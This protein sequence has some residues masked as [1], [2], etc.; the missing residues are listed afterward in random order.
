VPVT[1]ETK[2]PPIYDAVVISDYNKG[3]ITYELVEEI[4]QTFRGPVFI[5]TK[6]TELARFEG[7]FVKINSLENSL[8]KTLPSNLIVTLGKYGTRYN[9]NIY[10]AA[11]VEVADVC[12]AGDTFLAALVYQYLNTGSLDRAIEYANW[13]AAVTVQHVGVYAPTKE[14]INEIAR[15]S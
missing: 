10:P 7:A 8:A 9:D 4:Q 5:D 6:K 14:E 12:G 13:A 15:N 11:Q 2:I 3:T 1:L